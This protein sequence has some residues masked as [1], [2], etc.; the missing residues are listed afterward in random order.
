MSKNKISKGKNGKNGNKIPQKKVK[1]SAKK[2]NSGNKKKNPGN[3]KK[4]MKI[5]NLPSKTK[6]HKKRRNNF[7]W[8]HV[9]VAFALGSELANKEPEKFKDVPDFDIGNNTVY[10]I[11]INDGPTPSCSRPM[12]LNTGLMNNKR[13]GNIILSKLP[14]ANSKI[15]YGEGGYIRKTGGTKKKRTKRTK[16]TKRN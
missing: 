2:K 4:L 12:L 14:Y 8:K 6:K 9:L 5:D 16:R 1:K 11:P 15:R 3:K 13:P 7:S 10:E